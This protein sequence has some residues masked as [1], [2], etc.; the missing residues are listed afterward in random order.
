MIAT[1]PLTADD[2]DRAAD[3]LTAAFADYPWT[4]WCVDPHAHTGRI[5]E[6]QRLGLLHY[7]LPYGQVSVATVHQRVESVAFWI[8][9]AVHVPAALHA[10]LHPV[11][12][13]LEGSR[14]EA[15]AAAESELHGWRPAERHFYLATIGTSPAMQGL[16]LATLAMAPTL[17]LADHERVPACL[18]TSSTANVAFYE[19]LGFET[20]RH[21]KVAGGMGP[22]VWTMLRPPQG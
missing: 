14:H 2:I 20:T 15:S 1:R 10:E 16:G 11:F 8:D 21:W 17:Q 3:V 5:R 4:R 7:G 13:E 12:A 22:D 19:R 6:L 18:E 9:T